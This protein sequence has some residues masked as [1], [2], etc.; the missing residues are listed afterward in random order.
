MTIEEVIK[1]LEFLKIAKQIDATPKDIN[2]EALNLAIKALEEK[3]SNEWIP[4]T[5]RPMTKEEYEENAFV[6]DYDIPFEE[7]RVFTCP[8]PDDG[9]EILISYGAFVDKDVVSLYGGYI[10]LEN[11]E[12]FEEISAWMPL[13]EPYTKGGDRR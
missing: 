7:A 3:I 11:Y 2:V 10:A 6:G 8:L 13:P 4:V 9:Q 12:Y 1:H 5:S